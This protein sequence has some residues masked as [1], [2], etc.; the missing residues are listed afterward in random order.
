MPV[1]TLPAR[2]PAR[3]HSGAVVA[4]ATSGV[5]AGGLV[6]GATSGVVAGAASR[7]LERV[8]T[9]PVQ[10][11]RILGVFPAAVYLAAGD[12]VVAVL[13]R[14][15]VRLP[16]AVVVP[17]ATRGGPFAGI[18]LGQPATVGGGSV[19]GVAVH[20]WWTP[21]QPPALVRPEHLRHRATLLQ[22]A[23]V[24]RRR[25][26]APAVAAAL[27]EVT[28]GDDPAGA[29]RALVGLGAG[30]TP[31]GDDVL[32]GLLLALRHLGRPWAADRLWAAV[33]SE[34]PLATT[35]LSAALLAAA[36]DGDAIGPA[37]GVLTSLAGHAPVGPALDALL[38]V[39]ASS[40]SDL[41][42]GLLAGARWR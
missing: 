34:V 29:A 21:A 27:A 13:S 42:H 41:A 11:A 19:L 3:L 9:G 36:A 32:G 15:A 12:D 7:R 5:V 8:L 31:A 30:L 26:L 37:V 35:A 14:D 10:P 20:R 1:L 24:V 17:A 2:P 22:R 18:E 40:G 25:A 6:A 33:A 16:L 38:A 28:D 4:G 23:L 39:G